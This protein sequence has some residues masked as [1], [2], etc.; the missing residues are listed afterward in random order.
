M[1]KKTLEQEINEFLE[2]WDVNQMCDFLRDTLP[3]FELYNVDDSDD[4]VKDIVGE[5][6]KTNVRLIRTVYLISIIAERHAGP[7]ANIK[8]NFKDLHS[9]MEKQI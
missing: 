9:R 2:K 8:I 1:P 6:N 5:E 4:W 7:L 3:L